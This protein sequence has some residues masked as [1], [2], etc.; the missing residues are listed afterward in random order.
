MLWEETGRRAFLL[1]GLLP[2]D[3]GQHR[4]Q[5]GSVQYPRW[6]KKQRMGVKERHGGFNHNLQ[7][8][9]GRGSHCQFCR[10]EGGDHGNAP[11]NREE[12]AKS[13]LPGPHHKPHETKKLS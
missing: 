10:T 9:P 7:M 8:G 1:R 5:G 2:L 11:R 13:L 3:K 4:G 6:K 12:P